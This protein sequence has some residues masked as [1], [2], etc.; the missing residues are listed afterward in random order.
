M[1]ATVWSWEW[2]KLLASQQDSRNSNSTAVSRPSARSRCVT[3]CVC[4]DMR[5]RRRCNRSALVVQTVTASASV[6]RRRQ[7]GDW[8]EADDMSHRC[9]DRHTDTDTAT[10][11]RIGTQLIRM[12]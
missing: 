12:I 8:A 5:R 4:R 3:L 2:K 7:L 10:D 9:D 1:G 6:E 11:M